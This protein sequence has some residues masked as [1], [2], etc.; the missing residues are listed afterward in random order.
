MLANPDD[1]FA[2]FLD[3]GDL[4]FSGFNDAITASQGND[5]V[6]THGGGGG[7]H[8]PMGDS[9]AMMSVEQPNQL[10]ETES[11]HTGHMPVMPGLQ[12]S[13]SLDPEL[14]NQQRENQLHMHQQRYQPPSMVPP[15]PNSIEMHADQ[16]QYYHPMID[17][18]QLQMYEHYQ[19]YQ[20][21][22]VRLAPLSFDCH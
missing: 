11:Q 19:R 20:K 15:T 16:P 22:Q 8:V 17:Q 3:F 14:F 4:N 6:L 2:N 1:E 9:A 12:D 10:Q 18:Q 21:D 7:M 5:P 13:V